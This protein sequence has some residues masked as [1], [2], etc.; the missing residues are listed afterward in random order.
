MKMYEAKKALPRGGKIG[1]A[2][3]AHAVVASSDA[4]ASLWSG[5]Q[6]SKLK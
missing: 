2:A 6:K 5:A 4:T 3:R 1:I